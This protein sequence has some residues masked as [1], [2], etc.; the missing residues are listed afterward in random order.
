M[1]IRTTHVRFTQ[2]KERVTADSL[3]GKPVVKADRVQGHTCPELPTDIQWY[4]GNP[5]LYC[6]SVPNN[7]DTSGLYYSSHC[8][9]SHCLQGSSHLIVPWEGLDRLELY[10]SV[11]FPTA[12][13]V[14][15]IP[16]YHG[17]DLTDRG[18]TKVSPLCCALYL[19]SI[20]SQCTMGGT[21][22]TTVVSGGFRGG[23]GGANAPPFG[24]E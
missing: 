12:Y 8:P 14:H 24:G 17:R 13:R 16:L 3:L 18:C 19:L 5:K 22:R 15:P 7:A 6:R 23:K 9:I 2:I 10:Q 20:P 11:P 21:G 4:I 1:H